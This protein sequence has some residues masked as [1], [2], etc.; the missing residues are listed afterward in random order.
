[1]DLLDHNRLQGHRQWR[2]AQMMLSFM[3]HGYVWQE[4][5]DDVPPVISLAKIVLLFFYV[6]AD[7]TKAKPYHFLWLWAKVLNIPT[8]F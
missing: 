8:T 3:G 5:D 4:G 6:K 7:E 2:L 1:M